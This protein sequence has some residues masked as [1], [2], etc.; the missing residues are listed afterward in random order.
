MTPLTSMG[1][2]LS[3][4]L[5]D[6]CTCPCS[7]DLPREPT[8]LPFITKTSLCTHDHKGLSLQESRHPHTPV[9]NWLSYGV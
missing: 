3:G 7:L 1:V 2:Q 5:V 4:D 6:S 9:T 8:S